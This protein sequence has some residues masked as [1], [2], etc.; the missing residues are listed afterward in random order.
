MNQL[1]LTLETDDDT[2]AR[3]MLAL[4]K[5]NPD[6]QS[7]TIEMAHVL[8]NARRTAGMQRMLEKVNQWLDEQHPLKPLDPSRLTR[9]T[10]QLRRNVG[11]PAGLLNYRNL[12][13]FNSLVQVYFAVPELRQ[14]L[15]AYHG[16]VPETRPKTEA[17]APNYCTTIL[18]PNPLL[19]NSI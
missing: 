7:T 14:A 18:N 16:P 9:R 19:H 10:G 2:V 11:E 3:Y 1:S 17:E 15:F 5:Q 8:A 13:Y 12:C 6:A 4:I